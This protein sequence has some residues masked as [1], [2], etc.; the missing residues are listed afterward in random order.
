MLFSRIRLMLFGRFLVRVCR[1]LFLC[2]FIRLSSFLVVRLCCVCLVLEGLNLL[3]IRWL[4]LLFC[5]VVVR[6]RVDR[7]KDVL[8]LMM[9]C[10]E[11][12][13]VSM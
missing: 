9:L 7:L 8:N 10:V 13:C 1:V 5:S 12:L 6:C 11:L 3:L 4:L 2:S